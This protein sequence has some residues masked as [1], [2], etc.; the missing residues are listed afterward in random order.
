MKVVLTT[1]RTCPRRIAIALVTLLAL[2]VAP[3]CAPLCAAR[4][5]DG[6][7]DREGKIE[8]NHCHHSDSSGMSILHSQFQAMSICAA[9]EQAALPKTVANLQDKQKQVNLET[10]FL[11]VKHFS[12]ISSSKSAGRDSAVPHPDRFE[13]SAACLILRI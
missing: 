4:T 13:L 8:H 12:S 9:V 2:I 5:C 1:Q 11:A 3:I 7:A 10:P 6:P